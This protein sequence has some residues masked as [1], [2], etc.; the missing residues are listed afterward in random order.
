MSI[1]RSINVRNMLFC[2][3]VYEYVYLFVGGGGGG[4][5]TFGATM[6][7]AKPSVTLYATGDQIPTYKVQNIS[8]LFFYSKQ[9]EISRIPDASTV[10]MHE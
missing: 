2:V 5:S 6:E 1:K 3:S 7:C 8:K 10:I 4:A 9:S